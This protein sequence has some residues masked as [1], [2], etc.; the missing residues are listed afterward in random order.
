M[1]TNTDQEIRLHLPRL[2]KDQTVI[3]RHPAKIKILSMGRRWGKSVLGGCLALTAAAK[4]AKVAWIAPTYKNTR[5]LWRTVENAIA[6]LVKEKV[7]TIRRVEKTVEFFNG[8]FLAIYSGDN[9]TSIL[10]EWFHLVVIDEAARIPEFVWT[11]TIQPTLADAD[12]DALLISTPKRKNWFYREWKLGQD[13]LKENPQTTEIA[14]WI[15]PS[16][17]NPNPQIKKAA[18]QA[19]KRVS[20]RTYR[21]EWKAEFIDDGGEVFR[22]PEITKT[23][24]WQDK[25]I[26][27]HS[28]VIGIDTAPKKDYNAICVI[29]L[30]INELCYSDRF[31]GLEINLIIAR[32]IGV[33]SHFK[34]SAIVIEENGAHAIVQA[35]QR[36]NLPIIPFKTTNAS[37]SILVDRLALALE[38]ASLKIIDNKE[39]IEELESIEG[40]LLPGGSTRYAAP[41]GQHDDLFIATALALHASETPMY[42]LKP[43]LLSVADK[44]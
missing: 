26:L 43:R 12:G 29:D 20:S 19:M 16:S 28:Y 37:K 44:F 22:I 2:R 11:D 31:N 36:A 1:T 32:I 14:S 18:K 42:S 23:A 15:A 27:N 33:A 39:L 10:G 6:S 40:T 4:G 38:T 3:F 9:P 13:K 21:Q 30:T 25:A 24:V 17:D 5:P 8:G 34:P 35:L 7:A 41:E